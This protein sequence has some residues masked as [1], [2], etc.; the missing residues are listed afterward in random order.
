MRRHST[1]NMPRVIL[2][3][4]IDKSITSVLTH[5]QHCCKRISNPQ[6]LFYTIM[7]FP[8]VFYQQSIH[9]TSFPAT[10]HSLLAA[11]TPSWRSHTASS[12]LCASMLRLLP[13]IVRKLW[14]RSSSYFTNV[15][16]NMFYNWWVSFIVKY[17]VVIKRELDVWTEVHPKLGNR[18]VSP[19][20]GHVTKHP[21][22]GH[23]L[24]QY[25]RSI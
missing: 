11:K 13:A 7:T 20:F 1:C 23:S 5:L 15:R 19:Y 8:I 12:F 17:Y 22:V 16:S 10:C 4:P 14:S 25:Q 18:R 6:P 2:I 24:H 3:F 9:T 21:N